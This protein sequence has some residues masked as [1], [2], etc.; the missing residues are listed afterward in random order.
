MNSLCRVLVDKYPRHE[1]VIRL[2]TVRGDWLS[3]AQAKSVYGSGEMQ[4]TLVRLWK[5]AAREKFLVDIPLMSWRM[6]A[7]VDLP[8]QDIRFYAM[9]GFIGTRGGVS[10]IRL[11]FDEVNDRLETV[12]GLERIFEAKPLSLA[13]KGGELL[14]SAGSEGL[15][16]GS[17]AEINA[18]S[19]VSLVPAAPRSVRTGWAGW[20]TVNYSAPSSLAYIKN[21]LNETVEERRRFLYSATDEAS[22]RRSIAQFAIATSDMLPP[23]ALSSNIAYGF[24]TQRYV[25]FVMR[26]GSCNALTLKRDG[27]LGVRTKKVPTRRGRGTP[28]SSASFDFGVL[29]EYFASATLLI[30]DQIVDIEQRPSIA[31]R[32]FP[33]SRR[34]RRC[35]LSTGEESLGLSVLLPK[36]APVPATFDPTESCPDLLQ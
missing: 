10:E 30:H 13:S 15:F 22:D 7:N 5:S 12:G 27:E 20:D 33:G 25:Y 17:I 36:P 3:N 18:R 6:I 11:K 8:V 32:T 23:E 2:A 16:H 19:Q 1:V 14:I 31:I 21:E 28:I 9:R 35:I 29:V 26:D 24:N 34:F 4:A